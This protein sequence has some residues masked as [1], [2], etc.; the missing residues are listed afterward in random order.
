[1]KETTITKTQKIVKQ[2][3]RIIILLVIII[4]SVKITNM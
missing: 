2:S 1:M 4:S 3:T